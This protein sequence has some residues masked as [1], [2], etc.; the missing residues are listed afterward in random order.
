MSKVTLRTDLSKVE[1]LLD[2][3]E[4]MKLTGIVSNG[5][6]VTLIVETELDLPQNAQLV[7]DTDEY[8]NIALVGIDD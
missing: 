7:Y 2:L 1:F 4:E 3:P 6:T 5:E 8:G